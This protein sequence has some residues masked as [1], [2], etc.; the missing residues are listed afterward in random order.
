[1]TA[2]G[3]LGRV[4]R[5]SALNRSHA[6]SGQCLRPRRR[7]RRG[8]GGQGSAAD[9]GCVQPRDGPAHP[10]P[11][12]AGA[13]DPDSEK[14]TRPDGGRALLA[15]DRKRRRYRCATAR[16]AVSKLASALRTAVRQHR[17]VVQEVPQRVAA[18]KAER[19][20]VAERLAALLLDPVA[21]R[22]LG[23][24]Y[25]SERRRPDRRAGGSGRESGRLQGS[26]RDRSPRERIPVWRSR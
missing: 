10:P 15:V 14:L 5:P 21:L 2:A 24:G 26:S 12:P 4:N 25:R 19:H 8:A 23:P 16:T 22:H 9:D 20:P 13:T 3:P 11:S 7:A 17:L 6:S 1:M 18:V